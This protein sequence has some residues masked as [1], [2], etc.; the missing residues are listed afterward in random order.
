ME[1]L[2]DTVFKGSA[3]F[4]NGASFGHKSIFV[5]N[6]EFNFL[7]GKF[8]TKWC[9]TNN[10]SKTIVFDD[11]TIEYCNTFVKIGDKRFDANDSFG[12]GPSE[13]GSGSFYLP[14]V[15]ESCTKFTVSGNGGTGNL[16][17]CRVENALVGYQ[18]KNVNTNEQVILKSIDLARDPTLNGVYYRWSTEFIVEK[19]QGMAI[20]ANT[21]KVTVFGAVK[22]L[23]ANGGQ[24]APGVSFS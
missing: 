12:Q 19:N 4:W 13:F 2:S 14:Q 16:K 20:P 6:S 10:P 8:F 22:G 23:G 21:Y 5:D 24:I 7:G 18:V 9:T 3:Y 17:F 1:I 15:D 11:L